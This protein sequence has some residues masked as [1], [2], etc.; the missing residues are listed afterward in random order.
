VSTFFFSKF[1]HSSATSILFFPS[2]S[3]GF[4]TTATVN[5]PFS[6]AALA[7]TGAAPEPVPPPIP[8]VIKSILESP[9]SAITSSNDSSAASLPI[10]KSEPAPSPD[11]MFFPN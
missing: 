2:K 9:S 3:N 10:S 8:V 6:L 4:V 11:V 7:I 5:I 1:K